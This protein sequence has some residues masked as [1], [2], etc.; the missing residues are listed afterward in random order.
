V[1]RECLFCHY[2]QNMLKVWICDTL[3]QNSHISSFDSILNFTI[4]DYV[5]H[6]FNWDL[7]LFFRWWLQITFTSISNSFIVKYEIINMVY[8]CIL[9]M[10]RPVKVYINWENLVSRFLCQSSDFWHHPTGSWPWHQVKGL[11]DNGAI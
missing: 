1:D 7:F 9:F 4:V 5:W 10:L 11:L 2:N 8:I 6:Y 3:G